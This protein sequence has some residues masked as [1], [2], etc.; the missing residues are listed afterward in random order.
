MTRFVTQFVTR[1]NTDF[2]E[3]VGHGMRHALQLPLPSTGFVNVQN[4]F[5][6]GFVTHIAKHGRACNMFV[7]GET[8]VVT[9]AVTGFVSHNVTRSGTRNTD[10]LSPAPSVIR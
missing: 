2:F 3:R 4:D 5:M 7:N 9:G 8:G 6:T 10:A 1:F